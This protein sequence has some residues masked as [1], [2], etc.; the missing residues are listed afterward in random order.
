M[1]KTY[2]EMKAGTQTDMH[3]FEMIERCW[4][5]RMNDWWSVS[6]VDSRWQES[7]VVRRPWLWIV[8]DYSIFILR[9]LCYHCFYPQTRDKTI[10]SCWQFLSKKNLGDEVNEINLLP[11]IPAKLWHLGWVVWDA[12][13]APKVWETVWVATRGTNFAFRLLLFL[14]GWQLNLTQQAIS[15]IVSADSFPNKSLGVLAFQCQLQATPNQT[16][17]RAVYI[18]IQNDHPLERSDIFGR[19][20]VYRSLRPCRVQWTFADTGSFSC[21]WG[22]LGGTAV[23]LAPSENRQSAKREWAERSGWT[24]TV[25]PFEDNPNSI[26]GK[27]RLATLEMLETTKLPHCW[28]RAPNFIV[29]RTQNRW[30]LKLNSTKPSAPLVTRV[31]WVW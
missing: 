13:G 30:T 25:T 23:A 7:Q 18:S 3:C 1:R 20:A 2:E 27:G 8:V 31:R 14:C 9:K 22:P 11:W 16:S 4:C 26:P 28:E 10:P 6:P 12:W 24:E 15:L 19:A 29:Q 5:S 21:H 17:E